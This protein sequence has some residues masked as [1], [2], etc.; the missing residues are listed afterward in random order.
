MLNIKV[1]FDDKGLFKKIAKQKATLEVGFWGDMYEGNDKPFYANVAKPNSISA[2]H[3]YG[4][5]RRYGVKK[6]VSVATVATSNEFGRPEKNQPPRPFMRDTV[7]KNWRKWRTFIQDRLPI[8]LDL[9]KTLIELGDIAKDDMRNE[10]ITFSYPPNRPSTIKA[11]GF[12]DPLIDSGQM[13]ESVRMEV[14]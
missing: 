14:R 1:K 4:V 12:N 10:I 7:R 3:P 6:P 8:T 2:K 13:A 5:P 9:K 11:K